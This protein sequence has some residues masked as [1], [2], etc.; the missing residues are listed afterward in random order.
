MG[1]RWRRLNYHALGQNVLDST[2]LGLMVHVH[3]FN[4]LSE[5]GLAA[6]WGARYGLGK[7]DGEF[8]H[9]NPYRAIALDDH[10]GRYGKVANPVVETKEHKRITI[11]RVYWADAEDAPAQVRAMRSSGQPGRRFWIHGV[12]WFRDVSY[13]QYKKFMQRADKNFVLAAKG[14]AEIPC[15]LSMSYVTDPN[16][17]VRD[18]EVTIAPE[19]FGRMAKRVGYYLHRSIQ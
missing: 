5:A 16:A 19:D 1:K 6:T 7:R 3:T 17:G 9:S 8:K 2:Y 18:M 12:E 14:Q 15:K 4:D 11:D 10:F 13:V